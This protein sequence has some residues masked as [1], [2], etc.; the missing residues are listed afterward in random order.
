VLLL[1]YG[2]SVYQENSSYNWWVWSGSWVASSDPRTSAITVPGA[3]LSATATAGNAS[4]V[5][6]FARPY[7]SGGGTLTY[8]V[9]SNPSGR[10]ASGSSSPLTVSGLTNG[11]AYT[12]TVTAANSLGAGAASAASNSV[13]PTA[14]TTFGIRVSGHN[15]INGSGTAVQLRGVNVSGPEGS[16]DNGPTDIWRGQAPNFAVMKTWGINVVRIPI[17]EANWLGLCSTTLAQGMT[18][19]NFQAGIQAAVT[20]ANAQGMYVILDLHIVA[21]PD[22]CPNGQNPM[23]DSAHSPTFWSQ[24]AAAYKNNPAVMFEVFNEPQ[25]NFPPTTADWNNY[26]TGQLAE[27]TDTN[28]QTMLNAI[29]ATGATNVVLV[30]TLD[31]ASTFGNNNPAQTGFTDNPPGF[32]L[33]TD[34]LSPQQLVAVQH[35][36]NTATKYETGANVVLNKGIPII[37]TEY[38]DDD[39]TDSDTLAVYG[40]ADPGGRASQALTSGGSSFPGVSY[41]AWTW[42]FGYGG[43]SLIT[44]TNG[45]VASSAYAAEVKS[46]YQSRAGLG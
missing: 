13:T 28:T 15:I 7:N 12:F 41:V 32:Q 35:Y 3:P 1:Y 29:R 21:V 18:P 25:G 36:Y 2:G 27:S 4:A 9:T 20:A 16:A 40:W 44:D 8:T 11:T 31:F 37:L 17:A 6:A 39:G 22:L 5:V 34:T 14:A 26:V 24:V 19:A 43:W 23:A 46:H 42:N 10:T 30:D 45:D 38:G 33:P